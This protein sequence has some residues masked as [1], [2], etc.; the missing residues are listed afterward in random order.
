MKLNLLVK[1]AQIFLIG[2]GDETKVLAEAPRIYASKKSAMRRAKQINEW[3]VGNDLDIVARPDWNQDPECEWQVDF[4]DKGYGGC[5]MFA[6][7]FYN[8][9]EANEYQDILSKIVQ[10]HRDFGGNT[11]EIIAK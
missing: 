8:F 5:I 7:P 6:G 10:M 2:D 11:F 1:D 3:L 4:S 9:Q